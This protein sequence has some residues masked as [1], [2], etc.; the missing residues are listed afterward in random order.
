MRIETCRNFGHWRVNKEISP[1]A[2]LIIPPIHF[3][4]GG[5][6]LVSANNI[7]KWDSEHKEENNKIGKALIFQLKIVTIR[8]IFQNCKNAS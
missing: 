8:F 5:H 6:G 2:T 7:Q 4:Q 1:V 3:F